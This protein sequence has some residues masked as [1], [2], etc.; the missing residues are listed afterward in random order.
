MQ[1]CSATLGE[2]LF[3]CSC[4][5]SCIH[6]CY[7]WT[8]H[9][10]SVSSVFSVLTPLPSS[11]LFMPP[12]P[13]IRG[14]K[15]SRCTTPDTALVLSCSDEFGGLI[16]SKVAHRRRPAW[17]QVWSVSELSV[18]GAPFATLPA[19]RFLTIC[20]LIAVEFPAQDCLFS[21]SAMEPGAS[22]EIATKPRAQTLCTTV[23]MPRTRN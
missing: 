21:L 16:A 3:H 7:D 13:L 14:D 23:S 11:W 19:R 9:N 20:H 17:L 5:V 15:S 10:R 1:I 8:S 6:S 22:T 4:E 18:T 12:S 2:L